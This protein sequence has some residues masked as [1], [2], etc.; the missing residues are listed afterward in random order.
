LENK[1]K[2][3]GVIRKKLAVEIQAKSI[4][5]VKN[6]CVLEKLKKNENDEN[7]NNTDFDSIDKSNF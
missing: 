1:P 7:T 4:C 3:M 6:K 2:C 5:N